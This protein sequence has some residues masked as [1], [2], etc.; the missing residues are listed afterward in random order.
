MGNSFHQWKA[1]HNESD[2]PK[3]CLETVDFS[4]SSDIA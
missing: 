3:M 1:R 4:N 2:Q